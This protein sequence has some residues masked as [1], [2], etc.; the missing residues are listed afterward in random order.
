MESLETTNTWLAILAIV[1]LVEFL[2]ILAAGFFAYRLYT[3]TIVTLETVER[4]HIAPLR[5]R[6]DD[7]LDE[8]QTVTSKVKYA[9]DAVTDALRNVSGTGHIVADAVKARTWPIIG[10]FQGLKSAATTV[11]RNGKKDYDR[12]YGSM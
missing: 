8:V 12:P 11:L 9:Q 4:V 10:I 3:R 1:S 2:M 6:V 7:I 5:A